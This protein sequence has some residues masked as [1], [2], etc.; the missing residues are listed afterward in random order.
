MNMMDTIAGSNLEN[1]S[2]K[3]WNLQRIDD[4]CATP[5]EKA[6]ERQLHWHKDF[7]PIECED[8]ASF[9]VILGCQIAKEI[10]I[11]K[12][13][14]RKLALV[15]S[16]GPMGMYKWAVYFLKDWKIKCDHVYGFNMDEWS[17]VHGET[18]PSNDPGAF[19]NAM[20]ESFY[21]PLG[22]LTVPKEQR[23]FATKNNLPQ[24]PEKIYKI[25][26]EGGKLITIYGIGRCFHIAFWEP[27]F[28]EDYATVDE[29]KKQNIE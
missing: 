4:C 2:P 10:K 24:Y 15:L 20:E 8:V 19:Q 14:G 1:F 26:S 16:V 7:I 6:L 12:E 9:N 28:A 13:E 11:A 5:P 18:L 25:K 29:W 17:N 22:E 3:G 21:G 23:N 27:H